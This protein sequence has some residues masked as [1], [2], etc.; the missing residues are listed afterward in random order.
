[1]FK[2][3]YGGYSINNKVYNMDFYIHDDYLFICN[4]NIERKYQGRKYSYRIFK[5]LNTKYKKDI[6]LECFPT[7][8]KYYTKLGFE[9]QN[10]THD[11]YFEMIL[12]GG[13]NAN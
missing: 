7:L 13:N 10:S 4:F 12:K 5:S 3:N 8:L 6:I 11:G 1:M 9:I 2:N